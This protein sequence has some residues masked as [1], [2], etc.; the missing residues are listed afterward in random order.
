MPEAEHETFEATMAA[1]VIGMAGKFP[2]AANIDE[3]REN[4]EQGIE[5][6]TF[7]ND[8]ELIAAG[9]SEELLKNPAYV[10]SGG[11]VLEEAHYFDAAFFDYTSREAEIM[12]PQLRILHECVYTALENA[13]YNPD[14]Y[15]GLIGLYAGASENFHWMA[16][17]LLSGKIEELGENIA[18]QCLSRDILCTRI[19]HR[20]NLKGPAIMIQS[21]CSTSLTAIHTAYQALMNG[22]CDIA[23]AGGVSINTREPLG[24]L[25]REGM[26]SS[27]DGHCRAFDARA[28]GTIGGSG[29]GIVALKI[30]EDALKDGDFIY[31][32]VKGTAVNNDGANKANFT[33][34]SPEG[35]A[36]V[37]R[38]ALAAADIEPESIG[39]VETH[40]TGTTLGDPIE[41]AGLKLAF[42]TK[43]KNICAIGS[44]KTNIGHLDAAAGAA[45][46]IK[47]VLSLYHKKIYPSLNFQTPNPKIDLENS[48]FYV[49]TILK[50]WQNKE[51]PLRAGVSSFGIGGTNA[52]V[53]LEEA[54]VTRITGNRR[55]PKRSSY[56]LLILSAK[57]QDALAKM[58]EN[59]AHY[60]NSKNFANTGPSM[61]DMAYTLQVG[62]KALPW[63]KAL[64]CRDNAGDGAEVA[65][66]P[67]DLYPGNVHTYHCRLDKPSAIFMFPGQ[68]AQYVNMGWDLYRT[69]PVFRAEIDRCFEILKPILGYNLKEILY[70]GGD[71]NKDIVVNKDTKEIDQTAVTQ[72]VIFCCEYALARLI[73]SWGVTPT[74]M[75]GHSIGEYT[76]ACLAGVFSLVDALKLVAFRGQR[77]QQ[78]SPGAMLS[79]SLPEAELIALLN[80]EIS[81]AAVNSPDLCVISGPT[82]AI[83]VLGSK[84]NEQGH[85]NRLLHTSHA[86]HSP[87]MDP[88]LPEFAEYMRQIPLHKPLIPY[89]ANVTGD[90]ITDREAMD[91]GYWVKHLRQTVRFSDGLTRL[92]AE[93]DPVFIEIGPGR[94]LS[95]FLGRCVGERT[96][97][98]SVN[99][100]KPAQENTADDYY[101]LNSLGRLWLYGIAIDWQ[102]FQAC[103]GEKRCRIPLPAYPFAKVKY[104]AQGDLQKMMR[105]NQAIGSSLKRKEDISDWFLVDIYG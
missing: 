3:F 81:L 48:P 30:L 62:R 70:P 61:A 47:T 105:R 51:Y 49:N 7:Y 58:T 77:M 39:Y 55:P 19:A 50:E 28:N 8:N 65:A 2:G 94:V 34:P 102:K 69:E 14:T 103:S 54:P 101:L 90:W 89:I 42:N 10:K 21:A 46:F 22:E 80:K 9:A 79:V 6:I 1:A 87:M 84:L 104:P 18:Q 31:A 73:M 57:T 59:L 15:P 32:V 52:H 12:D 24:Y 67:A 41:I 98:R 29:V 45:G 23:L 36:A 40:G 13:G 17:S 93:T 60:L 82:E 33:A 86:F 44:V 91:P 16:L 100:I 63:R 74:A 5:S 4:L 97:C 92:A 71:V 75:I 78:L 64:V 66:E 56:H 38:F 85:G 27:P 35:Q 20:L 25:Y 88:V 83:A 11:G 53:I 26:I 43:K 68:G 96:G 37:I 95:T 99:L 72:P 76:A